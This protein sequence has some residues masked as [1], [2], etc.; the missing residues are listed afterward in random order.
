M[1]R[2][3]QAVSLGSFTRWKKISSKESL[4]TFAELG[5]FVEFAAQFALAP[6]KRAYLKRNL[7]D[8]I[9]PPY[10]SCACS[11]CCGR[12]EHSLSCGS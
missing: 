10:P 7:L 1:P 5:L 3:R 6:N 2:V 4:G 8:V 12:H 9:V 11:R